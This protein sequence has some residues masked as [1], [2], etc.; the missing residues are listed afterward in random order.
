MTNVIETLAALLVAHVAADFVLQTRWMAFN[1][2]CALP[3]GAHVGVVWLASWLCLGAS[4]AALL[5]VTLLSLAHL[6][7][8]LVK[9]RV[10]GRT[11][12]AFGLDQGVHVVTVL[13]VAIAMP[14][15]WDAGL[16]AALGPPACI[17]LTVAV[18]AMGAVL[19]LRG[20]FYFADHVAAGRAG[21]PP[22]RDDLADDIQTDAARPAAVQP[23]T[24]VETGVFYAAMLA[25]P[26]PTLLAGLVR[27]GAL[28][29]R[30][31]DHATAR[32]GLACH[33]A[34]LGWAVCAG[35][36]THAMLRELGG[37]DA[38]GL[39]VYFTQ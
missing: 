19:A 24:L 35:F 3:L 16:W 13:A 15:L 7:M 12:V 22:A 31:R 8:D 2:A 17:G 20:G 27:L 14:G 37:L 36:G 6:G 29:W 28:G 5:P 26:L 33:A 32:P 18:V 39:N 25:L 9:A 1:K 30:A 23:R 38:S 21:A 10:L 34:A 4:T 11:A